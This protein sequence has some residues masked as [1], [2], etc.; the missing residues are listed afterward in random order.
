M[1]RHVVWYTGK[2]ISE[3]HAAIYRQVLNILSWR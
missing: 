2:N 1:Q 3:E